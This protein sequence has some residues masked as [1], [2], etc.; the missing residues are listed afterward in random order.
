MKIKLLSLILISIL[1]YS[2]VFGQTQDVAKKNKL[3]ISTGYN[4]G[5]LKNLEIAPISRYD[6]NGIIYKLA[7]ERTTKKQNLFGVQLDYL[8]SELKTDLIPILNLDYSKIGLNISSLK[9]AYTK[10]NFSIHLGLH[11]QT[12]ISIYSKSNSNRSIT[13]QMFG[14]ASRYSYQI[15]EKHKLSSKIIIPIVLLR[16]TPS[17][18]G[19]YSLTSY[20]SILWNIGYEYSLSNRFSVTLSYD[21]NYDRLQIPNAFRE[22]QY[23]LN[24]GL[25]FKF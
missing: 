16:T 11:S 17:T 7:Y 8:T 23:Q 1:F 6:Y 10:N 9:K 18:S 4:F 20:Q 13:N 21:F 3:E 24:L 2:T 14:F 19:I 12:N 15:N 5:A 25:I 22:L